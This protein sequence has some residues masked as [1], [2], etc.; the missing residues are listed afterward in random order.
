MEIIPFTLKSKKHQTQVVKKS[1]VE[2][3]VGDLC[4]EIYVITLFDWNQRYTETD[5]RITI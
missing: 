3:I 1:P 2:N 5:K 4:F